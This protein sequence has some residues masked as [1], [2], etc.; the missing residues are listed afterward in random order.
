MWLLA[1]ALC[2]K[3][4]PIN[5]AVNQIGE[6][7]S[8]FKARSVF[9]SVIWNGS[10]RP[11]EML[12]ANLW[13]FLGMFWPLNVRFNAAQKMAGQP[14]LNTTVYTQKIARFQHRVPWNIYFICNKQNWD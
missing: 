5:A 8:P 7:C 4:R 13:D 10:S 6:P 12:P 2:T 11:F 9:A 14:G 1:R 3:L